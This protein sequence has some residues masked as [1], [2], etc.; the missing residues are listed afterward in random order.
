MFALFC[1]RLTLPK[2]LLDNSPLQKGPLLRGHPQS[3]R[4]SPKK[5]KGG[6]NHSI[7]EAAPPQKKRSNNHESSA[8]GELKSCWDCLFCLFGLR[9]TFLGLEQSHNHSFFEAVLKK[10]LSSAQR[11]PKIAFVLCVFV[12][13]PYCLGPE[14]CGVCLGQ[15]STFEGPPSCPKKQSHKSSLLNA[16]EQ[17]SSV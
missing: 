6:Q 15:H 2:R 9:H 7:F 1:A 10:Q 17:R 3:S 4:L 16:A 14:P 8:R 11:G 12:T 5:Y 13:V